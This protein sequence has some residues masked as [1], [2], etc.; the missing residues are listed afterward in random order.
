M[1]KNSLTEFSILLWEG[2]SPLYKF[3][4]DHTINS[5]FLRKIENT[6]NSEFVKT[7]KK[8]CDFK[9]A[10]AI[11]KFPA[12]LLKSVLIFPKMIS[13]KQW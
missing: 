6:R 11:A 2:M 3:H 7:Q 5:K 9:K 13:F 1:T 10:H 8:M 4:K 12:P